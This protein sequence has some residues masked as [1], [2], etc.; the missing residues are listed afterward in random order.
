M[1]NRIL[2]AYDGSEHSQRASKIA[3]D[4]ARVCKTTEVWLICVQDVVP[5]GL[6]ESYVLINELIEEQTRRGEEMLTAARTILGDGLI[7]Q[8]E[9][10]FGSPAERILEYAESKECDLIVMGTRGRSGIASLLLGSQVQKVIA[11]SACP[12]LAVK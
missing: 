4:M 1:F 10:L 6:G 2:V 11:T 8:S 3:G 5:Y 7:I 9:L 12:V